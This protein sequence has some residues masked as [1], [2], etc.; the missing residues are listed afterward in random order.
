MSTLTADRPAAR[1]A[2]G[3]KEL[4]K[5]VAR[6]VA[7]V[8]VLPWLLAYWFK[9]LFV[10]RD[11]AL[12][13]SSESLSLLPGLLGKYLRRAFLA[14]VLAFGPLWVAWAEGARHQCAAAAFAY[15]R[16]RFSDDR[17]CR[18]GR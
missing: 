15:V 17:D 11:R 10:G 2:G 6:G 7:T 18:L 12:E 8:L 9:T 5:A 3:A 14:W 16:I 13:G 4:L 1:R